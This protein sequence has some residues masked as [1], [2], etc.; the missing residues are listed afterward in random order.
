MLVTFIHVGM[1]Q[2]C[3][4]LTET[5]QNAPSKIVLKW[6]NCPQIAQLSTMDT[7]CPW[8]LPDPFCYCRF[9][10]H[11]CQGVVLIEG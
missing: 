9:Q 1:L 10:V 11:D 4:A 6:Q 8:N 7:L 2:M 3:T 5:L